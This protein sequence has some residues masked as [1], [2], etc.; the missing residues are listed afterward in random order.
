MHVAAVLCAGVDDLVFGAT[1]APPAIALDQQLHAVTLRRDTRAAMRIY[2]TGAL[3]VASGD[4][5]V[6]EKALPG[7][8]ARLVLALL[9]IE[10]RRRVGHDEIAEE[11]WPERLPRTWDTALRAIVSKLRAS[12]VAGGVAGDEMIRS[13]SGC[14]E[15]R[16][17][18]DGWLDLDA[19][20]DALHVAE[21]QLDRGDVGA[22]RA[23]AT[24]CNL[25]CARHFLAGIDSPWVTAQ[26]ARIQSMRV[27]ADACLA[28]AWAADG[29]FARSARAAEKALELEPF[30]ETL[31]R[32]LISSYAAAG[33][34]AAAAYAYRRC[35]ELLASE[36]G[37][38]PAPETVALFQAA[39]R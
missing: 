30:R 34:R 11:L 18:R 26:R 29:D 12:L 24:V 28:E 13:V 22:A 36:L 14:Y 3:I 33:D 10:H 16:F 5:V 20:A 2:V 25:I 7:N 37:V 38:S 4:V 23:N 31:H 15:L 9:A 8:Q 39:T 21:A 32:R 17:P 35:R 6:G 19:A 27:R 1:T